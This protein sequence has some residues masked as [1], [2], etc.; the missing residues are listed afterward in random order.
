[1]APGPQTGEPA[2]EA[3][4]RDRAM[5]AVMALKER[6][7]N[8]FSATVHPDK[9]VKFFPYTYVDPIEAE[10]FTPLDV[11]VFATTA[12]MYTWG[13][14][15][16]SGEPIILK[17]SDYIDQY[18]YDA[19]FVLAEDIRENDVT[20]QGNI[21]NNVVEAFPGTTVISFHLPPENPDYGGMDWKNLRL[22]M[23]QSDGTWYVI[24]VVHDAWTI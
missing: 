14:Q 18:V 17:P 15:D 12:P 3:T 5:Q 20:S 10:V 8:A 7:M 24:A 9:G 2:A 16:G 22:V 1:M 13:T 6:D 11:R 19:D 23:E 21:L 4:A